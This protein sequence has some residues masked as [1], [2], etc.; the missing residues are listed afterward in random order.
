[1]EKSVIL[2]ELKK[3]SD[4][5]F[6]KKDYISSGQINRA[7]DIVED[8]NGEPKEVTEEKN[9]NLNT[10]VLPKYNCSNCEHFKC[11]GKKE[12]LSTSENEFYAFECTN[13]VHPLLDCV[14]RGFEGH[15]EQPSF[16]Q[17]LNK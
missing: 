9:E 5:Y 6:K 8:Y 11:K 3:I 10:H 15:S 12:I 17:T 16:S 1:M 4:V 13:L 14:L 7:M 2:K